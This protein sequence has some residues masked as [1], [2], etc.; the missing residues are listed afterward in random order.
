LNKN[1]NKLNKE[2]KSKNNKI[3]LNNNKN[4]KSSSKDSLMPLGFKRYAFKTELTK[5]TL[6]KITQ[7]ELLKFPNNKNKNKYYQ[8]AEYFNEY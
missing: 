3:I 2:I 1:N 5:K 4:N 7:S 8:N 6:E